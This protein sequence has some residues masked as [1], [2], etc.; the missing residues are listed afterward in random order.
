MVVLGTLNQAIDNRQPVALCLIVRTGG[1]AHRHVGSKMIV[2]E[3][4]RTLGSIGGGSIEECIHNEAI[5]SLKDAKPKFINYDVMDN[6]SSDSGEKRGTLSVY[7]EPF[8]RKPTVVVIGA[9]HIGRSVV[10]LANWLDFRVVVSDDREE[11]CSPELIP[12]GD[13]YLPVKMSKIPEVMEIDQ[14]TYLVLITRNV[15]IDVDGLPALLKTPAGYIGLIGSKKRWHQTKQ[16]LMEA[17]V[18]ETEVKRIKSPIGLEI[19]AETPEEIAVSVMAQVIA[20]CNHEKRSYR[21]EL[22]ERSI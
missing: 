13:Q 17:G 8:L 4:G 2:F 11:L 1:T 22:L 14:Q 3:D 19:N 9:G 16:R 7:I 20:H 5:A 10:Y 18:S 12:G 6:V 21:K 15:D